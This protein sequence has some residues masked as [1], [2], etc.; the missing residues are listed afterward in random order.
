MT[1]VPPHQYNTSLI[2]YTILQ[3]ASSNLFIM[4]LCT[5]LIIRDYIHRLSILLLLSTETF[6]VNVLTDIH[7]IKINIFLTLYYIVSSVDV[8]TFTFYTTTLWLKV[9]VA[10]QNC[11]TIQ[12]TDTE[13]SQVSSQVWT[14]P[15]SQADTARKC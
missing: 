2:N 1:N 4:T 8:S 6:I 5:S 7:Q 12:S 9:E 10:E 13:E 15:G 14:K 11:C 3:G